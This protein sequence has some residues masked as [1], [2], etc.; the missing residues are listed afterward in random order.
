MTSDRE[1][2]RSLPLLSVVVPC[3]DEAPF[4]PGCLESLLTSDYP[5]D[6][7]EVLVVDGASQD[8]TAEIV[9]RF[10][11]RD[12]RVRLL[13]N[14]KRVT[15]VAMNIG[16]RA[17]T[18]DVVVRADAHATYPPDYLRRCVTVLLE[19]GADNSGGVMRTLPRGGGAVA[20][21]IAA[22]TSHW[23]GVGSSW[24]RAH[25]VRATWVDTVFGGCYRRDVFERVGLFN[26]RLT[27]GQDMEF[28]RR[29]RLAG[30][31]I[32]L[33]PDIRCDYYARSTLREFSRHTWTNGVWAIV[34]FL[35]SPVMPVS[36]RHLVPLAF[37]VTLG[38][39]GVVA[40]VS[41]LGWWLLAAVALSYTLGALAVAA[42]VSARKRDPW[43]MVTMPPLFVI[44]HLLYGIGSLRGLLHVT[45]RLLGG[46][47][48]PSAAEAWP[49]LA[50]A[51]IGVEPV[52]LP[53]VSVVVPARNEDTM[54]GACL[55]SILASDYP[56]GCLE[57][58]VLDG[59][60]DDT[61]ADVASSFA[62]RDRRVRVL[63]NPQRIIPAALNL[64]IRNAMGE[65]VVRMDAHAA[66]PP[67]YLRRCVEALLESGAEN[68]GGVMRTLPR[69]SGR[70]AQGIA[71]A[72]SHWFGVGNSWFRAHP[73]RARMVDTVFGGCYRRSVFERV[74]LFNE[75]LIRGEDMEFNRRLRLGGGQILLRPDIRC[76]YYARSTLR[77]FLR[78]T[79]TNGVWAVVPFLHSPV[80][81]V[82]WRHL[83]PLAFVLMLAGLGALAGLTSVGGW[84]LAAV[85][86]GYGLGAAVAAVE[87][88]VRTRDPLLL[89][90]MPPLFVILHLVYGAGSLRGLLHVALRVLAGAR[91]PSP[92]HAWPSLAPERPQYDRAPGLE[93]PVASC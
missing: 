53:L 30:G 23:F 24:F 5:A 40:I 25:P 1:N 71:A 46:V 14:S 48:R 88:A 41:P 77:E 35:H 22:V 12:A 32:R 72:T 82:S 7:L 54:I 61:T 47:R 37:V 64:G 89:P 65:V 19:S 50:S 81:P 29:L 62:A 73:G 56:A 85:A 93:R 20:R 38:V 10:A 11:A 26:E 52:A 33:S 74:G 43:L 39:L 2:E 13:N 84:L 6:R 70:I 76:D 78:H 91:R 60:S 92:V 79:W 36:W 27:R 18:G 69:G 4:I 66:Y 17:A 45:A 15:P 42:A 34:P 83:V 75:R 31:R 49:R 44:L 9:R 63:S 59:L 86:T 55:E 90:T 8:G 3:R 21:G 68:V 87:V 80:M 16:I 28:N 57:V 51:Q 67:D 58:L